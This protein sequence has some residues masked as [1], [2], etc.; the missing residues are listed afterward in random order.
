MESSRS[1][2][3]DTDLNISTTMFNCWNEVLCLVSSVAFSSNMAV[4]IVTRQ[5]FDSSVQRMNFQ[6]AS[7]LSKC[8]LAKF[9]WAALFFVESRGFFLTDQQSMP[10]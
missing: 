6:K 5:L 8:S 9:K 4:L 3:A 10:C 2:I 1:R 7:G